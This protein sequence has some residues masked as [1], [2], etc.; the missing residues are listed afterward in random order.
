MARQSGRAETDHG[1]RGNHWEED[2]EISE[3][4]IDGEISPLGASEECRKVSDRMG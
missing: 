4:E 3:R 1:K 2:G